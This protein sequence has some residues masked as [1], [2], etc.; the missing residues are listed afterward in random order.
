MDWR[1]SA[2]CRGVDPELF[3]PVGDTGPAL[4]QVEAAKAVCRR[5]PVSAECLA[6]A[7]TT[8]QDAGVWG[9]LTEDE[10][11]ALRRRITRG[12]ARAGSRA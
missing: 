6:F 12:G 9:G 10:R 3:F 4:V 7:L 2:A 5:C 8:R 11:A 1:E